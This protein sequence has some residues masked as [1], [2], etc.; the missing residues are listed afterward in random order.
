MRRIALVLLALAAPCC[1]QPMVVDTSG[2]EMIPAEVAVAKLRELLP[3]VDVVGCTVPRAI[4]TGAEVSVW[5]VDGKGVEFQAA[6]K[7]P[8][9]LAYADITG[10]RLDRLGGTD[11][12]VR[13]FTPAQENPKKDHFHFNWKDEAKARRALELIEALRRKR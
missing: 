2:A 1:R 8:L 7:E 10:A 9:R 11:Y 5:K 3:T 12:Q 13:I 4:Y 6:G